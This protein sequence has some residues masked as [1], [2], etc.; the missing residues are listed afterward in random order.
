MRTRRSGQA[1]SRLLYPGLAEC[2]FWFPRSWCR[3]PM[4]VSALRASSFSPCHER[5]RSEA[6]KGYELPTTMALRLPY[7]SA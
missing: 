5:K 6:S 1:T 7:L 4:S 3:N 2:S